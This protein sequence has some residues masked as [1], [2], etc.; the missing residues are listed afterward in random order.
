MAR[1]HAL[2][3]FAFPHDALV[4]DRDLDVLRALPANMHAHVRLVDQSDEMSSL[5][6]E[7]RA[8]LVYVGQCLVVVFLILAL[9]VLLVHQRQTRQQPGL[10]PFL[11]TLLGVVLQAADAAVGGAAFLQLLHGLGIRD[12]AANF[13]VSVPRRPLLGVGDVRS[14]QRVTAQWHRS[15]ADRSPRPGCRCRRR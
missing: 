12:H 1:A 5:L 6:V 2:Q 7:P 4:K 3:F 14:A 10:L 13:S 11:G 15:E 8:V 9:E